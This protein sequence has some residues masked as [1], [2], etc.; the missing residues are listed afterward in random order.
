M[1]EA[2]RLI[3]SMAQAKLINVQYAADVSTSKK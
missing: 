2:E 1:R 3:Q